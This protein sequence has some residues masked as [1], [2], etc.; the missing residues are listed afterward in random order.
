MMNFTNYQDHF[1]KS[2]DEKKKQLKIS[3]VF[4]IF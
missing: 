4:V 1:A 2:G 3:A